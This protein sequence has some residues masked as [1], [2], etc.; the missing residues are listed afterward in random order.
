[1]FRIC[2]LFVICL[3]FTV[4]VCPR[5]ALAQD[6]EFEFII[7]E[8]FVIEYELEEI[9]EVIDELFLLTEEYSQ[10]TDY[11]L[12]IRPNLAIGDWA[13]AI[14]ATQWLID[15]AADEEIVI[16]ARGVK[17]ALQSA[18]MDAQDSLFELES[19]AEENTQGRVKSII[20]ESSFE[21]VD[22]YDQGRAAE[23]NAAIDRMIEQVWGVYGLDN[24]SVEVYSEIIVWLESIKVSVTVGENPC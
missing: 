3:L 4:V 14:E 20:L 11:V 21:I 13:T 15:N 1:M 5:P 23:G 6:D 16:V 10:L 7:V 24:V 19:Y 18:L 2:Y 8:E 22:L 12:W 17:T 9:D